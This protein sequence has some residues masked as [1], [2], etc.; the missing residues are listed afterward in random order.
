MTPQM[1]YRLQPKH[2][3][4]AAQTEQ[5]YSTL[6][7]IK[8]EQYNLIKHLIHKNLNDK[9]QVTSATCY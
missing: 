2:L 1:L 3:I 9:H 7:C 5:G 8:C 4:S 6:L